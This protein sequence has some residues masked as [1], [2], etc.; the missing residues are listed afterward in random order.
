MAQVQIPLVASKRV[1]VTKKHVLII[2]GANY[3]P[4]NYFVLP[5]NCSSLGWHYTNVHVQS[6]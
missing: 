4:N 1:Q 6:R 3:C 5:P 2:I